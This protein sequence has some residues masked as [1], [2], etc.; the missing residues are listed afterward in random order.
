MT[1][2]RHPAQ[3]VQATG[4]DAKGRTQY[5]YSSAAQELA[6]NRKFEHVVTFAAALPELRGRVA[7]DLARAEPR[8][9]A[10][11]HAERSLAAIVRLL[12]RGL[13]GWA[14]NATRGTTTPTG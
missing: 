14:T 2:P 12:D 7:A 5:R 3:A 11:P 13:F 10:R 1:Q 8:G 4:V 6:A 9:G